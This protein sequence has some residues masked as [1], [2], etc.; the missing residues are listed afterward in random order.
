LLLGMDRY[1]YRYQAADGEQVAGGRRRRRSCAQLLA[2][3]RR[4]TAR[5]AQDLAVAAKVGLDLRRWT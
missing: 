5:V 1:G 4:E 2:G 3:G